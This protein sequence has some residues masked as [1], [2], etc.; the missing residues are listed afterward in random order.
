MSYPLNQ[1]VLAVLEL[2]TTIEDYQKSVRDSSAV[3]LG[4][5]EV[6]PVQAFHESSDNHGGLSVAL[7]VRYKILLRRA[8]SMNK[9]QRI[10]IFG[11]CVRQI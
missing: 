10:W 8:A 2:S 4:S 1:K 3:M 6:Y 11:C 5:L 9:P 7:A